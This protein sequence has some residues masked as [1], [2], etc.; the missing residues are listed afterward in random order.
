MHQIHH[1]VSS[2]ISNQDRQKTSKIPPKGG[3]SGLK[4]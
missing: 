1:K 2:E 4:A 3:F